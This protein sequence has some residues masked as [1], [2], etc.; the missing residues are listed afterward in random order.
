MKL[1]T[2][3]LKKLLIEKKIEPSEVIVKKQLVE[4]I[5]A[6]D[7]TSPEISKV[8][9]KNKSES[10]FS[11]EEKKAQILSKQAEIEADVREREA[12]G[13]SFA[14]VRAIAAFAKREAEEAKRVRQERS[15][16]KGF[17][18]FANNAA[19]SQYM[20]DFED[21]EVPMVKL[22]DASIASPFTS[23]SPSIKGCVDIIRQG[24]CALVTTM[25]MYQILA[26]NCL[27]S[28]Y[29]LSVLYLDRV[30]YAN[31]QM[32]ALGM[33]STVASVTLSRATPLSDLSSVRPLTSIFHP[34]LFFSLAGQFALHLGCMIY[35]TN[36]AKEYTDNSDH[37]RIVGGEFKPNV[38]STVI[39]L[40]NG[41]QTVS[42]C[43]VNYKGRPFMKSM[44]DN[45]GLM[46]SLGISIVGVF[47]LCTEA[48]PLFNKVLQ[49]VPMPDPRFARLLTGMLA[50]DVLGAFTWDQLCLLIFAP[51]IFFA[52][53]KA[54]TFRDMRQVFKM[55]VVSLVIIYIV[56]N[57]DYDEIE[58][59]QR[60]MEEESRKLK[61]DAV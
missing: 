3:V 61:S 40:I 57:I 30:R 13:E 16:A 44:T 56:A 50:L 42:V 27:I 38:M 21:G 29:S 55:A 48:M 49:I 25:Q 41:V 59:Q 46:Y 52:T 32:M 6:T 54:V 31:S 5:L 58:R 51:N 39:F 1:H 37:S 15:G 10:T 33:I 12:R 8:Q 2:S 28:S 53:I 7:Q 43:A 47:L 18:A 17:A 4:M 19:M 34:A 26:V 23:R 11:S 36:L 9:K 24:R 45:P 14:R 35:L 22:G 60:L 20:D